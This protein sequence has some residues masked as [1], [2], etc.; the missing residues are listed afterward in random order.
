MRARAATVLLA[1]VAVACTLWTGGGAVLA[2]EAARP[3]SASAAAPPKTPRRPAAG[4]SVQESK[5]IGVVAWRRAVWTSDEAAY[6]RAATELQRVR[7]EQGDVDFTALFLLGHAYSRLHRKA[8]A[9]LAWGAASKLASTTDRVFPGLLLAQAL[10]M[11]VER[12][13]FIA[14][15]ATHDS[16]EMLSRFLVEMAR[17]DRSQPFAEELQYLGLLERGMRS[18]ALAEFDASFVDLERAADLARAAG[19]TPSPE[20]VQVLV[21]ARKDVQEFGVA[22]EVA[23]ATLRRYPG[24]PVNYYVRAIVA[25]E[26]KRY[27]ESRRWHERALQ[28]KPDYAEPHAKLAFLAAEAH[29]LD[30]MRRHLEIF[31]SLVRAEWTAAPAT[32]TGQAAANLAAGWG[33]HW[34]AQGDQRAEAGDLAAARAFWARARDA[35]LQA[36]TEEAG[37]IRAIVSL[38]QVLALL[39]APAEDVDR[40]TRRAEELREEKPGGPKGY[41]DTFC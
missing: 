1:A 30:G 22:A 23:E 12:P 21:Q 28:L 41:R 25:A 17:Y 39:D 4:R 19:R 10:Y 32:R 33:A 2:Q 20:L 36:Y 13:G 26:A 37:C 38:V 6:R 18:Y 34:R 29:D 3:P 5:L 15:P 40:W 31:E 11:T 16:R 7:D 24:E 8:D 27:D 14:Q 35:Y 9:D